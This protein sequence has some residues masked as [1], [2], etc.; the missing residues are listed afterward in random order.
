MF[1]FDSPERRAVIPIEVTRNGIFFRVTMNGSGP[2]WF[3]VDSGAGTNYID[4]GAAKK[5]G[6]PPGERAY[7][8]GAGAGQIEV[9]RIADVSFEMPGLRSR[10]HRVN[11]IDLEPVQATWGRRLDG[12]F[13]HD[14]LIRFLV[15]IDYGAGRLTVADPSVH[16]YEGPGVAIP[17]EIDRGVPF[18]RATIEVAGNPPEEDRFLVDSGSQDFVDHPIIEKSSAGASPVETGVGLGTPV[19]GFFGKVDRF[20]LG[21]FEIRDVVGVAGGSGMGSRLIGGGVLS[22][23]TV[24]FDYSRGKMFLVPRST[25]PARRHG[26][27]SPDRPRRRSRQPGR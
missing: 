21:G 19:P 6:L 3:S 8:H 13:G 27:P 18:V 12:F 26:G 4:R 1:A 20:V 2:L 9:E 23:F 15:T 5:L 7:V 14:F 10:G 17:I 16:A 25:T 22:M 24:V 11:V